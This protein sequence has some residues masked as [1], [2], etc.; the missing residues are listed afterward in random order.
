MELSGEEFLAQYQV[1]EKLPGTELKVSLE[2]TTAASLPRE[3]QGTIEL[4]QMNLQPGRE[5]PLF[6][7]ARQRDQSKAWTSALFLML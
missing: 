6:I 2:R 5:H 3:L 1:I 4:A 7:C